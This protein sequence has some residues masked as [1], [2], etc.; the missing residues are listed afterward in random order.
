MY[1]SILRDNDKVAN[2]LASADNRVFDLVCL[3]AMFLLIGLTLF[4]PQLQLFMFSI[5][6]N[7]QDCIILPVCTLYGMLWSSKLFTHSI[8]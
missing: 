7:Q 3:L 4:R 8:Q 6:M 1:A 2:L 5:I